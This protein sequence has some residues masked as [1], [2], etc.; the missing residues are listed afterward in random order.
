MFFYMLTGANMWEIQHPQ[1]VA[2]L[3]LETQNG[4]TADRL[5]ISCGMSLLD[6]IYY[7]LNII[8]IIVFP[9]DPIY[10]E[11][12]LPFLGY[13]TRCPDKTEK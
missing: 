8:A 10:K 5:Q 11:L 1:H 9:S 2:W 7:P 13:F 3:E 6:S 4:K 12:P